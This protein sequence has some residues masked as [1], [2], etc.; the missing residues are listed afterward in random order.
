MIEK[1]KAVLQ[2]EAEAIQNIPVTDEFEKAIKIID[3]RVH[4]QKGKL[5]ASGMGKA[6]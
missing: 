1:I 5:V 6:G 2:Q 4:Q 3:Q